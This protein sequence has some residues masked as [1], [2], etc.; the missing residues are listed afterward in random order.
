MTITRTGA[1][2]APGYVFMTPWPTDNEI[3]QS[4]GFIMTVDG[5]MI[6]A[7]PINGMHDFRVQEYN[8]SSYLTYWNGLNA[9]FPQVGKGY[10][11][12]T[13]ADT[14]YS[15]FSVRPDLGINTLQQDNPQWTGGEVDIHEAEIT[16]GYFAEIDIA[17]NEVL[18][19]WRALD[20]IDQIPLNSS[21]QPLISIIGNGTKANPWDWIHMNAVQLLSLSG[22][23]YYL[24]DARHTFSVFLVDP[25][26]GRLVWNFDGETGGD[27]GPVP[28][29]GQF[30][31]QHDT[32]AF[33]VTEDGLELRLFD[34][35]NAELFNGTDQSKAV[36]FHLQTPPNKGISPQLIKRIDHGSY[37]EPYYAD[38]MG[39]Y[40]LLPNGNEIVGWGQVATSSEYGPDGDLRW[41]ASFGTPGLV[42]SYRFYKNEWHATPAAWDPSLVVEEGKAY[43]SWNGATD[44]EAWKVYTGISENSLQCAGV[45]RK[46]GFET[47]FTVPANAS[48][49][50]VGAI[51]GGEEVRRTSIVQA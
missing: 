13:F 20:H 23:D 22:K 7:L 14:S 6:Y 30:R 1:D 51:Q 16:D 35:H 15:N 10:G 26:D 21:R 47:F 3:H 28:E 39:S 9:P 8:E 34:N 32:R 43:V 18:Y 19:E 42:F 46:K 27:F 5:D 40:N 11:Q 36:I 48:Y 17:T 12:V 31:W 2:L 4:G 29:R 33:N 25:T 49:M 41:E 37:G 45:A 44:I 24:V 50:Q 38:S